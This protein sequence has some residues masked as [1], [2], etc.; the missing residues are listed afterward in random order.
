LT[1]RHDPDPAQIA[2]GLGTRWDTLRYGIKPYAAMG[3]LHAAIDA[4][5]AL[6]AQAPIN[7]AHVSR[8]RVDVSHPAFQRGGFDITRPIEPITAQMSLKYTVPVV[9]LDHAA[10]IGQY[11][12][13]RINR[14]DVW[15]LIARTEVTHDNAFDT[16]PD[17]G[18]KTRVRVTAHDGSTR[19][20]IITQ[21]RG[22]LGNPLTE[23]IVAK[24]RM[25]ADH[26]IE[27]ARRDAIED[28]VLAIEN[29]PGGPRQLM[30]LLAAP[31]SDALA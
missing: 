2:A 9:I 11:R 27:P 22:G 16:G 20:Q 17:T 31:V 23:E 28:T 7:P 29:N 4:V 25:L 18:Y 8:I 21:P 1:A 6:Q 14:A 12:P 10:L 15:D 24:Y 26:I 30:T 19:E 5:L 3:G 13:E